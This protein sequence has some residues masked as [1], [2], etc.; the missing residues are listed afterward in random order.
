[1]TRGQAMAVPRRLIV[2]SGAI[3]LAA[4]VATGLGLSRD[5][6]RTL[7]SYLFAFA[8]WGSL[9]LGAFLMLMTFHAAEARWVAPLRRIVEWVA[10]GVPALLAF[11]VPVGLGRHQLYRWA[12]PGYGPPNASNLF[13]FRRVYFNELFWSGRSALYLLSWAA[14]ALLLVRWSLAQDVEKSP[15]LMRKQRVLG[16]IALPWLVFSVTFATYDWMMSLDPDWSSEIYGLCYLAGAYMAACAVVILFVLRFMAS[17]TLD[18]VSGETELHNFSKLLFTS[19]CLWAYVGYSQYMLIWIANEPDEIGWIR[20]RTQ[21]FWEP[22]FYALILL[23]FVFPFFALLGRRPKVSP[24]Y[25]GA[26][27]VFL[28]AMHVLDLAWLLLPAGGS[29]PVAWTDVTAWLGLGGMGIAWVGWRIDGTQPVALGDPDV[30]PHP[31]AVSPTT[32]R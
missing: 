31:I 20:A 2:M 28:L 12:R 4:L 14:I 8:Y 29:Q 11:F 30:F 17:G 1:M 3:G 13:E 18:G 10:S 6:T 19:V 25:L 9:A 15:A 16:A 22:V 21:G 23:H 26:M 27:C 32:A 7:L 5:P 24:R